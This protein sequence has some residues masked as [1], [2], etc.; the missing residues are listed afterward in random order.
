MQRNILGQPSWS[1]RVSIVKRYVTVLRVYPNLTLTAKTLYR[2]W[3][4]KS[5]NYR[6][7][8]RELSKREATVTTK[9]KDWCQSLIGE[10]T[11]ANRGA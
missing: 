5:A 10:N 8:G 6:R 3:R 7:A 4:S 1:M 11:Q 9:R 2:R